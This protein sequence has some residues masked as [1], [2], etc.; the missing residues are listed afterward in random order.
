MDGDMLQTLKDYDENEQESIMTTL[1]TVQSQGWKQN[2]DQYQFHIILGKVL[3]E[4]EGKLREVEY[5]LD[6]QR[7]EN[8]Q[9]QYELNKLKNNHKHGRDMNEELENEQKLK[10]DQ[11]IHLEKYVKKKDE[12]TTGI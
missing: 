8:E 7:D 12:I 9:F 1:S 4:K 6:K 11:I 5:A 2:A 3:R 10:E